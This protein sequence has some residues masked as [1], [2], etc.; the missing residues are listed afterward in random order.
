MTVVAVVVIIII[1]TVAIIIV[2][3]TIVVI[4]ILVLI[5]VVIIVVITVGRH[6]KQMEQNMRQEI[7]RGFQE[8]EESNL[9]MHFTYD[10]KASGRPL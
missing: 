4:N 2:V 7:E 1:T 8:V 6:V 3:L 9:I 10:L 5:V